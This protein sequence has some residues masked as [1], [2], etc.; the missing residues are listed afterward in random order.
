MET[1]TVYYSLD[2]IRVL[3]LTDTLEGGAVL[4]GFSVPL[5]EIFIEE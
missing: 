5:T 1:I 4:F 3:R 2:N